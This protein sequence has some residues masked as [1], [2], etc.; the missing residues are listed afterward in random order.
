[1]Q[2]KSFRG[3]EISSLGM[4]NMR[5]P[6]LE[7]RG[8]IDEAKAREIIAY[9][10]DHGVN[11]FDT[12]YRYHE[13][14]SEPFVGRVL[15]QY[16]RDRWYIATKFPGHMMHVGNG[17]VEPIGYLKGRSDLSAE[18]IFEEQ[19]Q[20]LGVEYFD[21]YLLHNLCETS[22]DYYTDRTIG[23]V[24]Y[25]CKQK[26]AGRIRHLGFSA[27]GRAETIG[28]FLDAFDCFE[29]VQIQL[30]YLD[31]VLQ[32][33]KR[34]YE[35]ITAHG[36]PIVVMEPV[37]GGRLANL[38]EK[39]DALLK[40]VRPERS[41]ASWALR[42]LQGLPNIL[43]VLSGMSSMEQIIENVAL[44][45][46]SDPLD[47]TESGL[48]Q[49]AVETMVDLIPCTACRY[50]EEACPKKLEIPKLIGMYNEAKNISV[51]SNHFTLDAMKAGELPGACAGCG[52]CRQLCP[53]NID[54]PDVMRR[55]AQ[56]LG[57]TP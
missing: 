30:N 35:I 47:E 6:M 44:F 1:M 32:D 56:M 42:F 23:T 17:R 39:A 4:G 41:S 5:L 50:C 52:A 7:N 10:L 54:I 3:L 48:L 57:E 28:N 13:G 12:G 9:A 25:L 14:A 43:T 11:Y 8:E 55:Y 36:L 2:Y 15:R 46:H 24:E 18:S 27:H 49:Q 22:F 51:R 37:R 33:A 21:F 20:R 29:F 53:Q 34:K 16:P 40:S 31:W 45:E 26:Q 19:L 38:P